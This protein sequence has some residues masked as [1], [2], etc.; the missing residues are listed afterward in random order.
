MTRVENNTEA[1]NYVPSSDAPSNIK[2][3]DIDRKWMKYFDIF[4][5]VWNDTE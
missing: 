3:T 4:H 2:L 5:I 1:P